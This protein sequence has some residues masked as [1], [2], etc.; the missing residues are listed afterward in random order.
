M[1][2]WLVTGANRGIG[3]ELV[4]QA[5]QAGFRVIAAARDPAAADALRKAARTGE[6][7]ILALD[8]ADPASIAAARCEIADVA[9]DVL[10]NNAG[11]MGPK[12]QSALDMDFEGFAQT[13]AVNL[14][15]P[16]RVAQA[17]LANLERVPGAKIAN[18]SS[19]MGSIGQGGS[20]QLAYSASKAALN[21]LMR[22]T[23]A[24]LQA[25]KIAVG[26]FSPGWVRT[27]MGGSNAPLSVQDSV[28]GLMK[29]IAELDLR[30]SGE[31]VNWDG[32]TP[33]W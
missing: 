9:I 23:A 22:G 3:L 16:L 2:T 27:D 30:S 13:L 8:V 19:M 10:V 7:A 5:A 15:G 21:R 20:Y 24:E 18:I 25:K 29:R 12:R 31:F 26:I 11:V 33:P 32:K 1:P 6:I 17:F 28:A 4:K 14:L